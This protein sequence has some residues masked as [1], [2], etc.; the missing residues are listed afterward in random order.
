VRDGA[1]I[2]SR[3]DRGSLRICA[4]VFGALELLASVIDPS[5]VA[6]PR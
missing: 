2:T 6:K 4:R 5:S 1:K 3:P